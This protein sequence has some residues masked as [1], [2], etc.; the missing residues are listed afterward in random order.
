MLAV[1]PIAL[2]CAAPL[3]AELNVPIAVRVVSFVQPS[4]TGLITV[5]ILYDPGDAASEAE[6]A[7][8][9][10]AVGSGLSVGRSVVRAHRV[11]V[12]TMGSLS[13]YR[14]AFVTAGLRTEQGSIA[15]A[16]N[17]ASVLT[18]SSDRA[19]VQTGRCV[20][21]VTASPKVQITVNRAAARAANIRFG[22][23][24]LMLVKEI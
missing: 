13:G 20:V 15:I 2:G 14:V 1:G 16:A 22:S 21:G 18:I 12:S 7:S 23:A 17:R 5:A 24:F 19:C 4:P 3:A 11:P 9:E 10:R 6:A 8:I